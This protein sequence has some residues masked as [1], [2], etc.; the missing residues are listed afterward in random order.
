MRPWKTLD[1]PMAGARCGTRQGPALICD[2]RDTSTMTTQ[3]TN[4]FSDVAP[5]SAIESRRV[6][7]Q[8][9]LV[10]MTRRETMYRL[11]LAAQVRHPH[12]IGHLERVAQYSAMLA[13]VRGR[14]TN[15]SR[16]ILMASCLHD[17][18]KIGIPDRILGKPGPLTNAER[19]V[20]ERHP[21][22]GHALLTD[23]GDDLLELA[24]TIALTHHERFDGTGYPSGLNANEIPVEGRIVAIADAFD[25]MT[26]DRS[27][28]PRRSVGVAAET[29]HRGLGTQFDPT[30]VDHFLGLLPTIN[31]LIDAGPEAQLPLIALIGL[32]SPTSGAASPETLLATLRTSWTP[33]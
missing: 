18:G 27:Y 9:S 7:R 16:S 28:R 21:A 24:A 20:L 14:P 13:E 19:A 11:A 8:A 33:T 10:T 4:N 5:A 26:S 29:L 22:I 17:I 32:E 2:D 12:L 23:S 15:R 6:A 1:P 30:L 25:A 3:A 31:D